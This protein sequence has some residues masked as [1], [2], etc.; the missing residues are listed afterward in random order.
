MRFSTT[1]IFVISAFLVTVFAAPLAAPER[2]STPATTVAH[3]LPIHWEPKAL[4]ELHALG[5]SHD[6]HQAAIAYHETHLRANAPHT[7]ATGHVTHIAHQGGSNVHEKLHI[8]AQFKNGNGNVMKGTHP[9]DRAANGKKKKVQTR[10]IF[11]GPAHPLHPQYA[12]KE[13]VRHTAERA[14]KGAHPHPS[15]RYR[16]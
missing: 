13:E 16:R 6:E 15:I 2:R 4:Q 7:A 14:A 8:S 5:L 1:W 10:H 11:P 3:P 9:T 12:H